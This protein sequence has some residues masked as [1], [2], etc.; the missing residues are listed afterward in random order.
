MEVGSNHF[1]TAM[2]DGPDH[3]DEGDCEWS[4]EGDRDKC[5]C[6]GV[7]PFA[8]RGSESGSN[9]KMRKGIHP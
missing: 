4:R 9:K 3:T 8:E 7:R 5:K 6:S 2:L 1:H